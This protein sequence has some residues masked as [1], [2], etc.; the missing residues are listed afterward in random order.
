MVTEQKTPL[1]DALKAAIE[2]YDAS[3]DWDA[4]E[5]PESA[6]MFAT[7]PDDAAPD[8]PNEELRKQWR[9]YSS[10][11]G[12]AWAAYREPFE[13]AVKTARAAL[14]ASDEPREYTIRWLDGSSVHETIVSTPSEVE[15]EVTRRAESGDYGDDGTVTYVD[16]AWSCIDGT[17]DQTTITIDVPEPDCDNDNGHDWRSPYSVLG[18]LKENPGVWGNGG[19][20]I[21]KEVCAHCGAY[22]VT[23]TW[24]QRHDTGEQGLTEVTYPD[25]DDESLAYVERKRAEAAE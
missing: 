19:G 4:D 13:T 11:W 17:D 1:C 9:T 2:A 10:A 3:E 21:S 6:A 5:L 20:T 24:A 25:A 23:D 12:V 16:V 18:G 14:A 7:L 8:A 15:A 22:R